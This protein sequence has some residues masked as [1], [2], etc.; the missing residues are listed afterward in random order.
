[1]KN[2]QKSHKSAVKRFKVTKGGKVMHRSQKIRHLKSSKSKRQ[3]RSLRLE[4]SVEG[5]MKVKIKKL[6]GKA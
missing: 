5:R 4:K 6:L 1:M 2:K 3:L